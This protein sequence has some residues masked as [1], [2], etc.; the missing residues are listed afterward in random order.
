MEDSL[1]LRQLEQWLQYI[2]AE[3]LK[4]VKKNTPENRALY[5]S[6]VRTFRVVAKSLT[7]A[8]I[9]QI[10]SALEHEGSRN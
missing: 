1:I 6:K 3:R 10:D 4:L 2:Y 8:L 9:A 5:L 7:D